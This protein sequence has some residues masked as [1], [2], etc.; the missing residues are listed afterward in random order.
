MREGTRIALQLGALLLLS[1]VGA[2]VHKQ[3]QFPDMP[4]LRQPPPWAGGPAPVDPRSIPRRAVTLSE[5]RALVQAGEAVF[6]DS[7]APA[8]YARGHLPGALPLF[9]LG[10]EDNPWLEG[11][12]RD[13]LLI[14]YCKGP[15]CT[16]AYS[17]AARLEAL[18]FRNLA[19]FHGGVEAWSA[20]GFELDAGAPQE[21]P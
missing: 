4:W 18:G 17:L 13:Q 11:L 2:A 10:L 20:A 15:E 7:R 3:V 1:A 8:D 12:A 5:A 9:V 19:L 21:K 6:A 14:C 16:I